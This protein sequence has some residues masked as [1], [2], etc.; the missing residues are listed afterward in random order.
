MRLFRLTENYLAY[1]RALGNGF[2]SEG[3]LLQS[4]CRHLGDVQPSEIAT[5][6]LRCFIVNGRTTI[7]TAARKRRILEGFYRYAHTRGYGTFP[8]LPPLPAGSPSSFV[9]YIYTHDEL[10]CLLH[11]A[12]A[13]CNVGRALVEDYALRALLLLL[14]GA[15]LRL[16]EALSLKDADADLHQAVLTIRQTKF[17]KTRLVPIGHD[18][19]HILTEYR[20]RRD[21]CHPG[22]SGTRF[23]CLRNGAPMNLPVVEGTFRRL[24]AA[25]GVHRDG[26][27]RQQP[28]L[29]DLRHAA[30]VHRLLSWYRAG[31]DLQRLLP[32][33]ATY[34]GHKDLSGT[35]RY[36]TLIPQLLRE[37]SRR[38]EHYAMENR[39]D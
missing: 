4:F 38:F 28:R 23:F 20:D 22:S 18:L 3:S 14:Y 11:A 21:Q 15:G 26:G 34:L 16:G 10:R 32:Q 37:A 2:A 24:R 39:H 29:H 12:P 30:A 9:P 8:P 31:A 35:Q 1:R 7:A 5:D 17:Y 33:L 6:G 13:I 36:L 19:A 25:A 27:P